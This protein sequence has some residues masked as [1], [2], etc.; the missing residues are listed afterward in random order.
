MES[1]GR[2]FLDEV[3]A[4]SAAHRSGNGRCVPRNSAH[5]VCCPGYQGAQRTASR[6]CLTAALAGVKW[7]CSN[8]MYCTYSSMIGMAVDY[9]GEPSA[10]LIC[11]HSLRGRGVVINADVLLV[12]RDR[13][14]RRQPTLQRTSH[15]YAR[16]TFYRES[17]RYLDA[18]PGG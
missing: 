2:A 15:R 6:Q 13:R 1:L 8:R 14:H 7:M 12:H 9:G 4:R 17:P 10:V 3:E 16:H 5:C 18:A 11:W